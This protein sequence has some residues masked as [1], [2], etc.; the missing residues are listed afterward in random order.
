MPLNTY[1]TDFNAVEK[2]LLDEGFDRQMVLEALNAIGSD[3][4]L[5]TP[6][7]FRIDATCLSLDQ[8]S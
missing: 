6:F 4:A 5:D 7:K 3:G 8:D 1:R 2:Q